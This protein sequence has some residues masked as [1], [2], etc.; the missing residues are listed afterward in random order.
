[1][2]PQEYKTTDNII[3]VKPP[4][5]TDTSIDQVSL[6]TTGA[7]AS[8]N[9]NSSMTQSPDQRSQNLK[10][11]ANGSDQKLLDPKPDLD[12]APKDTKNIV[13]Y[14]FVL[15]GIGVLMAWNMF[16]TAKAY[17]VDY[18]L[19]IPKLTS[20]ETNLEH[21]SPDTTVENYRANFLSYL[22]LAAQ[23]P[24]VISNAIN[25]FSQSKSGN[26][27]FRITAMILVEIVICV[28]TLSFAITESTEWPGVFFY[29]T[30]VS[31]VV[32][33]SASGVYQSAIYGVVGKL[34]M[35][36]SNAVML[37]ANLSGTLISIV[38][39]VSHAIAGDP[40]TSALLYFIGTLAILI[41]CLV[42]FNVLPLN[43]F[44]KHFDRLAQ[45]SSGI[46]VIEPTVSFTQKLTDY[47][48][49]FKQI[50]PQC[51]NVFMVFFVTLAIFPAV[52][53]N[54]E[55]AGQMEY[56]GY[57]FTPV[58]CFLLFNATAMIGNMITSLVIYPG[59]KALYI[60]VFARLFFMPFF[61][62]CRYKPVSRQ[63]PILFDND[64]VYVVGGALLGLSSG[65]YSS[66]SMMYAPRCVSDPSKAGLA[67]M[68]A[69]FFLMLGLFF[70][71]NGSFFLSKLV[72]L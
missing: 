1:M 3:E 18:K 36:Y 31:V 24:N 66:L 20:N 17:F 42:T 50:W 62:L 14:T 51:L 43:K 54:I 32:M 34:P 19:A 49:V 25:L 23:I 16:I 59:P 44:Y 27:I 2:D 21:I 60:P 15:H 13:Y 53:A 26:M 45:E 68:M 33:N 63:W 48:D 72:E 6:D 65:Y 5:Y 61:L 39:I 71:V 69:S 41:A 58:T 57:Y 12:T 35:S 9:M 22:G 4:P 30:M 70:G 10:M 11:A 55:S 29:I 64:Y 52:H 8:V 47:W 28:L 40:K 37:G 56:L 67:S 38:D 7:T 46:K